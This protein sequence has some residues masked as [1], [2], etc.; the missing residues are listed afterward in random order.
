MTLDLFNEPL[1]AGLDYR[2]EFITAAE[3]AALWLQRLRTE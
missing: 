1:I 3:E 2:G